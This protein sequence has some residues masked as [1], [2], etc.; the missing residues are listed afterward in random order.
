MGLGWDRLRQELLSFLLP[1]ASLSCEVQQIMPLPQGQTQ[2][3]H[4]SAH[5]YPVQE[6]GTWPAAEQ[7]HRL[8]H[9]EVEMP[10]RSPLQ[11][12]WQSLG[13][14]PGPPLT[15]GPHSVSEDECC[16]KL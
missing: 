1:Q 2:Q 8:A 6:Q 3:Q 7:R 15:T 14:D 5:R 11:F 4:S 16:G 10:M 12:T 9:G 13:T